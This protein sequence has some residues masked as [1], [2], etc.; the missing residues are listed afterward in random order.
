MLTGDYDGSDR[1]YFF[2]EVRP[3]SGKENG[4]RGARFYLLYSHCR[5]EPFIPF[6]HFIASTSTS[7][8]RCAIRIRLFAA[9][10]GSRSPCSH[11]CSVRTD[12]PRSSA[13]WV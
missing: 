1:D 9:P 6:N 7:G 8:W 12:M 4:R 2:Q 11:F 3:G 10:D 5:P 13:N